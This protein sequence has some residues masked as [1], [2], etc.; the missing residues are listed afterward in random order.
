MLVHLNS[1]W[2][3][4]NLGGP[5]LVD[6]RH[7]PRYWATVWTAVSLGALAYSTQVQK[8][9]YLENFYAYAD[10]L[11]G[12][13][14]LDKVIGDLDMDALSELLEG[15]FITL[16]N[17]PAGTASDEVQWQAVYAF[18]KDIVTWIAK[19][20]THPGFVLMEKRFQRLDTLYHQFHV[21]KSKRAN[22]LRAL[23]ARVV[24]TLYNLLDPSSDANPFEREKTR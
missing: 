14:T 13:G 1:P 7:L 9:R 20:A 16:R 23:P 24:E 5:Q 18:V 12:F 19:G 21:Q 10:E 6:A 15:F 8:L 22:V 4:R 11:K 3:P 2:V 17:R